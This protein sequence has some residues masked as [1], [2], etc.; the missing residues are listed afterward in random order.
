MGL[1]RWAQTRGLAVTQ[2]G[3]QNVTLQVAEGSA[4][5]AYVARPA[6]GKAHPGLLVFQEAFGVNAHI[7]DVTE[8]CARAG[9]VAIAPELFHRTATGFEAKYSDFPETV[10]H[11]KAM[12][13]EGLTQDIHAAYDWLQ[14]DPQ[15]RKEAVA[16]I[17]FCMGG[18]ASFL[19]N[20]TVPLQAAISFY[21]GGIAPALLP[22]VVNLHAPML[23]FWGG[24][25]KHIGTEQ[26]RAIIDE[27]KRL[28]KPYVN[29]EISEA[30]HGFF[31]DARASYHPEAARLA[32]GICESFLHFHV[33]RPELRTRVR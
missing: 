3:T 21:G 7:R 20:A 5:N 6:D 24:R 30:E 2:I 16:S 23:F 22:Q 19:A 9:V 31:C 10:P 13:V 1:R 26:I 12:T 11:M 15:V 28:G 17:G 18:R 4:M 25:D 8:R 27:C 33:Q 14:G 32:W 29:V